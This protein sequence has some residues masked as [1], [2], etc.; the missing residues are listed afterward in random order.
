MSKEKGAG[1]RFLSFLSQ[2]RNEFAASLIFLAVIFKYILE[3]SQEMLSFSQIEADWGMCCRMLF[4][5]TNT[6]WFSSSY[7]LVFC[8]WMRGMMQRGTLRFSVIRCKGKQQWSFYMLKKG[9]L[10]AVI[11]PVVHFLGLSFMNILM[12][13]WNHPA[14][15]EAACREIFLNLPIGGCIITS[16]FARIL[17]SVLAVMVIWTLTLATGRALYAVAGYMLYALISSIAVLFDIRMDVL[18]FPSGVS[19]IYLLRNFAENVILIP[20]IFLI[21]CLCC[22]GLQ[23]FFLNRIEMETITGS[24]R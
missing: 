1:K 20:E 11:F 9:L 12:Y 23:R 19:F 16:L 13:G 24:N 4:S 5:T 3:E 17:V 7:W 22:Y 6:F 15:E 10:F 14:M 21:G 2:Y 18:V 8:V